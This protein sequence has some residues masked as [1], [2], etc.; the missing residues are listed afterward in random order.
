M[1]NWAIEKTK[2]LE[3]KVDKINQSDF[4]FYNLAHFPILAR[5][6]EEFGAQ[7]NTCKSNKKILSALIDA[8]PAV[9]EN[10]IKERREFEKHKNAVEKHLRKAHGCHFPGYYAAIGSLLGLILGLI[11]AATIYIF[12]E[13][14]VYNKLAL[15]ALA[16]FLVGGRSM[17][18]Y[19]DR[20][21]FKRNL[22]L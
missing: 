10:D 21:I 2:L 14:N 16:V 15:I 19:I 4:R 11:C 18:I 22:Q 1:M 6:S 13:N 7:C 5:R 12:T 9:L 20:K 17:G 8:L 3:T